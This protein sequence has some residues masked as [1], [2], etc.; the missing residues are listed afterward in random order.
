MSTIMKFG[1]L[2]SCNNES[3]Y[4]VKYEDRS[5]R[6]TLVV[7]GLKMNQDGVFVSQHL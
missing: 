6:W 3:L 5:F 7:W 1:T 4:D 2:G